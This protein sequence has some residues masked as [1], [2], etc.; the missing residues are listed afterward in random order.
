MS[1]R[2]QYGAVCKA[3]QSYSPLGDRTPRYKTPRVVPLN[4]SSRRE[5][6][7]IDFGFRIYD[8]GFWIWSNEPSHVGGYEVHGEPPFF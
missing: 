5:E 6:A 8:F 3:Q 2:S 4:R 1:A 7:L